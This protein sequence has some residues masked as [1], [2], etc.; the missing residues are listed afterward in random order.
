MTSRDD[1]GFS[2][3]LIGALSIVVIATAKRADDL[4]CSTTGAILR[5]ADHLGLVKSV[6]SDA[7]MEAKTPSLL[8][9]TDETA[10]LA[11]LWFGVYLATSAM[12]LAVL[13]EMRRENSLFLSAGFICGAAA[14][15]LFNQGVGFSALVIGSFP[16]FFIRAKRS[17]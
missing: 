12:I 14:L 8:N 15:L 1:Y 10:V 16:V 7:I 17:A 5:W 11:V 13:A 6:P 9:F 4:R 2:A 3:V